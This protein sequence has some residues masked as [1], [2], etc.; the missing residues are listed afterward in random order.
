M[1]PSN[2]VAYFHPWQFSSIRNL[3]IAGGSAGLSIKTV[4]STYTA[5]RRQALLSVFDDTF[6]QT[7]KRTLLIPARVDPVRRIALRTCFHF[8]EAA[9]VL[10]LD[11]RDSTTPAGESKQRAASR[12]NA[13]EPHSETRLQE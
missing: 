11:K 9:M 1:C 7:V 10:E 8:D 12:V 4:H 5:R 6:S 3:P 2:T 13:T